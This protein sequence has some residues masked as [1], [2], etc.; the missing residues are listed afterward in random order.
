VTTLTAASA[1]NLPAG[2]PPG[3]PTPAER[4]QAK[5]LAALACPGSNMPVQI[6]ALETAGGAVRKGVIFA[7]NGERIGSIENFQVDFVRPREIVD[8]SDIQSGPPRVVDLT[9]EFR[10][11][12][13]SDPRIEYSGQTIAVED[14][15]LIVVDRP[16]VTISF[17]ASGEIEI[18]FF[19]HPWSG[20]VE[21][22]A[23]DRFETLDLYSEDHRLP[24]P[25]RLDVG[26]ERRSVEIRT[27]GRR[28]PAARGSQCLFGGFREA[29]GRSIPLRHAKTP[30]VH[31]AEFTFEFHQL[32]AGVPEDGL[33]LD[34]GG[35]S[36]Q[37]DDAR[38]L[39]LDYADYEEPDLIAD[40]TK[41]PLA[42]ASIDAVYSTGVFEHI[43]EHDKAG[44]EIER[45][46]KAGGVAIIGW[47]FM[48]PIHA[49]G[50]HFYNAT[51]WGV[52][53]AF[54]GL[55][56]KR[57]W[58]DTSFAFLVRWGASVSGLVGRVPQEEIDAVCETLKKWDAQIPLT[59]K[60]YM[61]NG[62]WAE[63]VKT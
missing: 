21:T 53:R 29:T 37:I 14:T 42:D 4:A 51:P 49:E 36:R 44:A 39:N 26:A 6:T 41:L 40:A 54:P 45:V 31:G 48:Q 3:E 9:P 12:A 33:L 38:Y 46:L 30:Q 1:A 27:T 34:V 59:R 17:E 5:L 32:L 50:Q 52:E 15:A 10:F 62:V 22:R 55:K 43:A 61:A 58:Y 25:L 24:R 11:I 63:F 56:L 8:P 47:A 28:H 57:M 35:G 16:D 23:G 60:P 2:A 18:L 7:P 20:I 13:H 19:S